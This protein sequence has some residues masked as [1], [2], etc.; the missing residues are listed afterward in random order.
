[1]GLAKFASGASARAAN[2]AALQ[3]IGG[4]GSLP[5]TSLIH[6]VRFRCDEL[7]ALAITANAGNT[8]GLGQVDDS[9][10]ANA[11]VYTTLTVVAAG[12]VS[13]RFWVKG[14]GSIQTATYTLASY[15]SIAAGRFIVAL[16]GHLQGST[17]ESFY[18]FY[19]DTG[20]ATLLDGLP[21]GTSVFYKVTTANEPIQIVAGNGQVVINSA[22]GASSGA[23]CY[24]S[25]Y[26]LNVQPTADAVPSSGIL[27]EF[28]CDDT[29]ASVTTNGYLANSVASAPNATVSGTVTMLPGGAEATQTYTPTTVTGTPSSPTCAATGAGDTV[30]LVPV[31]QDQYS[32]TGTMGTRTYSYGVVS[33]GSFATVSGS[34][35]VTGANAGAGTLVLS[36]TDTAAGGGSATAWSVSVTITAAAGTT[37]AGSSSNSGID[38]ASTGFTGAVGCTIQEVAAGPATITITRN[39]SG[40]S[41]TVQVLNTVPGSGSGNQPSGMTPGINTGSMTTAPSQV[42]GGTWLQ[43]GAP[44][45]TVWN[46]YTGA[47]SGFRNPAALSAAPGSGIRVTYGTNV[48]TANNPCTW[49]G[50]IVQPSGTLA[51]LAYI[52]FN[53]RF[54]SWSNHTSSGAL[55]GGTKLMEPRCGQNGENHVLDSFAASATSNFIYLAL[56]S[57]TINLPDA[58]FEASSWNL[59]TAYVVGNCVSLSNGT[60]YVCILNHTN[61]T[62][63]NATYWTQICNAFADV[64]VQCPVGNLQVA[65]ATYI[66]TEWLLGQETTPGTSGDAY[67]KMW[68]TA[69]LGGTGALVYDTTLTTP[70]TWAPILNINM[71]NAA[72]TKGWQSLT[73]NQVFNGSGTDF[74]SQTQYLDTDAIFVATK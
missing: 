14:Q 65:A 32:D 71:L 48:P 23:L 63:P 18:E 43:A 49:G 50:D 72:S 66:Q 33:G 13:F 73:F 44:I 7:I 62:P 15:A 60:Q 26:W 17:F 41:C 39:P 57:P 54:A 16:M 53:S 59:A 11:K 12:Q 9:T 31:T 42:A 55:S 1:M 27:A 46:N 3:A 69:T 36:V 61:H 5:A 19:D 74:V 21:T 37:Y 28:L 58:E 68:L 6:R 70:E 2:W 8:Y 67:V 56:Q 34:G 47:P 20:T 24:D 30:Q 38:T 35:L 40:P 29:P 52:R 51:G 10:A 45:P 4:S 64:D 25:V 22:Q